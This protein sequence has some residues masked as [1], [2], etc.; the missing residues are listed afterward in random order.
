MQVSEIKNAKIA[1]LKSFC[2]ENEIVV[3][4]NKRLRSTWE[5]AIAL[6][7]ATKEAALDLAK[8]TVEGAVECIHEVATYD[9]A[10]IASRAVTV[11][12]W[13]AIR[14]TA[15]SLWQTFLVTIALVAIV[16]DLWQDRA[17]TKAV[18]VQLYRRIALRI[19]D[20][21]CI[22]CEMG[23]ATIQVNVMEPID[24]IKHSSRLAAIVT[25]PHGVNQS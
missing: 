14:F 6:Y 5:S 2:T 3:E 20:R 25:S 7:E 13:K 24:R 15:Q 1:Q 10:V 8:E 19:R 22:W 21:W 11:W 16:I 18:M 17:Q 4:G 9:N 23:E 12:T